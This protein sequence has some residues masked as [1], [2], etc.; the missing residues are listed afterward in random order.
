MSICLFIALP[1]VR[2]VNRREG[3]DTRYHAHVG[4]PYYLSPAPTFQSPQLC[5]Q[6]FY[7]EV[8]FLVSLKPIIYIFML[9][10]PFYR[11]KLSIPDVRDKIKLCSYLLSSILFKEAQALLW[12]KKSNTVCMCMYSVHTSMCHTSKT[13]TLFTQTQLISRNVFLAIHDVVFIYPSP[14]L[15]RPLH[16]H[17]PLDRL[18]L[19]PCA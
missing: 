6:D 5:V 12:P 10:T 18:A 14:P 13:S 19:E 4:C 16:P 8:F 3:T 15:E 2:V 11:S 17:L 7:S 1:F 9:V